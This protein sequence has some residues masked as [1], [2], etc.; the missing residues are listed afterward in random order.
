MSIPPVVQDQDPISRKL[1]KLVDKSNIILGNLQTIAI[2]T[3]E[4]SEIITEL[5]KEINEMRAEIERLR[6]QV[7][8]LKKLKEGVK[9]K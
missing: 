7:E 1:R 6:K 4:M 5:S 3:Y 8:E 9:A 2:T